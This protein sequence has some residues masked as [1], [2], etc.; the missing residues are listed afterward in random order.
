[1]AI[2][3]HDIT[4]KG[5]SYPFEV[6]DFQMELRPNAHG[7]AK[8]LL[9]TKERPNLLQELPYDAKLTIGYHT[10][11]G[12][13]D[14][15]FCGIVKCAETE[16]KNQ[17]Y[18]LAIDLITASALL[19]REAKCTAYQDKHM[20]YSDVAVRVLSETEGAAAVFAMP[21]DM[22]TAGMLVQYRETDWA[23][24]SRLA[25][26][27]G[28]AVIPDWHTGAPALYFG[29]AL[30]GNHAELELTNYKTCC[31]QRF[32]EQGGFLAGLRKSDFLY[33]RIE[34][35]DDYAMGTKA[36]I[37][38]V[39]RRIMYKAARLDG[40][41]V[42][43][44]C[45]WGTAYKV[46]QCDN[47]ELTGAMLPGTVLETLDER[48]RVKLDIDAVES[49]IFHP[50]TPITGNHFYCM[51]EV[52]TRVMLYCG[53]RSER[54]AKVMENVRE[55]G[56]VQRRAGER[57]E[58]VAEREYHERLLNP[59]NRFFASQDGKELS[60]LPQS[61]G[62]GPREAPPKILVTDGIGIRIADM[63]LTL[64]AGEAVAFQGDTIHVRAPSQVSMVRSGGGAISTF[65]ICNDFNV[66]GTIGSMA[67]TSKAAM[68]IPKP[69]VVKELSAVDT[70]IAAC[71]AAIPLGMIQEDITERIDEKALDSA[72]EETVDFADGKVRGFANLSSAKEQMLDRAREKSFGLVRGEREAPALR[73]MN[74]PHELPGTWSALT[75]SALSAIPTGQS[76]PVSLAAIS[77]AGT[78]RLRTAPPK[79]G[80]RPR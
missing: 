75:A 24:I 51:P 26:H 18:E 29:T 56:M 3:A 7:W 1:M 71:I 19:D 42:K 16:R 57:E 11:E 67:S 10:H 76:K 60:M 48:V 31:D 5:Y 34:T 50:W 54:S 78:E 80:G 6:L 21:E 58:A 36:S 2:T 53:S 25:G 30:E 43:F 17:Y 33:H 15:L 37:Q 45:D 39:T 8:L 12:E 23:F 47:E 59:N 62:L 63:A 74:L 41:E 28:E 72:S 14:T 64:E 44:T 32:Y 38:G 4:L 61:I 52:G 55:N 9:R 69:S 73:N 35:A 27:L 65:D 77:T 70:Y 22:A 20:T 49:C 68:R 79:S 13:T 46:R 40:D 66:S